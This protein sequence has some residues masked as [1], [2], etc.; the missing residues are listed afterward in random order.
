L[1]DWNY[2]LIPMNRKKEKRPN[3]GMR[4]QSY[5]KYYEFISIYII[6]IEKYL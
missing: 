3:K 6:S 2:V 5:I 4:K 1:I